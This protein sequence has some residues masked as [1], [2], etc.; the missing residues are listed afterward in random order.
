MV[1]LQSECRQREVTEGTF[2]AQRSKGSGT[3]TIGPLPSECWQRKD[4]YLAPWGDK[5]G[6]ASTFLGLPWGMHTFHWQ[7]A[8]TDLVPVAG[9]NFY[10]E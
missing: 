10:T 2:H 3:I 6:L 1:T 5:G 4:P 8:C 7:K 9:F